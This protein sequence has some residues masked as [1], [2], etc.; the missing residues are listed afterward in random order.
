MQLW[1][2]GAILAAGAV[3]GA[4]NAAV[5]SGTLVTFST[6]VALGYPPLV[7]NIS[8]NLGLITGSVAGASGAVLLLV[9]PSA[10]FGAVVP[11]L[12]GLAVVL[13][14]AQPWLAARVAGR[15]AGPGGRDTP[16]IRPVLKI[17]LLGCGVYGGYFGAAQGVQLLR[18]HDVAET[19]QA[20]RVWRGLRDAALTPGR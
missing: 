13:V 10:A 2:G 3:G 11:V 7:A 4:I 6:L 5:G 1:E 15:S 20:L 14:I 8:N 17:L 19:V 9:L 16:I 12:I 18:V